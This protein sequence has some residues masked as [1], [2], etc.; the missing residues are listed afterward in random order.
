MRVKYLAQEHKAMTRP[1]FEP[2]PL[3]PESSTLTTR[4]PHLRLVFLHYH[5]TVEKL[6]IFSLVCKTVFALSCGNLTDIHTCKFFNNYC[7][8]PKAQWTLSNNP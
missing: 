3:D 6:M 4:P 2:G 8:L 7:C 1:G 5:I